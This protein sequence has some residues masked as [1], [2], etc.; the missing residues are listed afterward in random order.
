MPIASFHEELDD[1]WNCVQVG[2]LQSVNHLPVP[3]W[4]WMKALKMHLIMYMQVYECRTTI[5][6]GGNT[7]KEDS[8]GSI[9]EWTIHNTGKTSYPTQVCQTGKFVS[10]LEIEDE[11]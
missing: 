1:S 5:G 7:L 4:K 2:E 10:W 3:L 6:I 9:A 8:C 11:L